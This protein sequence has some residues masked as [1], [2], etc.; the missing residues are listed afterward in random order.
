MKTNITL[1]QFRSEIGACHHFQIFSDD[2]LRP[3]SFSTV[4]DKIAVV[5]SGSPYI[6]L[7]N[8]GGHLCLSYIQAIKK[9]K[10]VGRFQYY[11]VACNDFSPLNDPVEVQYLIKCY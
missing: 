11:I 4:Y 3:L 5:L 6:A 9:Y 2:P 8:S 7:K 1:G 10:K